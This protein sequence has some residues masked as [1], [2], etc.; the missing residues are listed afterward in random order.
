VELAWT[1]SD[2]IDRVQRYQSGRRAG[3]TRI[4]APERRGGIE[5]EID[6]YQSGQVGGAEEALSREE[7]EIEVALE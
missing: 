2:L 6:P 3:K 7:I 4:P 1:F 5:A